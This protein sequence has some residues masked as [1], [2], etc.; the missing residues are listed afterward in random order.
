VYPFIHL[1]PITLGT[2]GLL[3]ATALLVSYFV[4]RADFLRRTLAIDAE[5]VVGITGLAGLVGAR[6]YH[7]MESPREFFAD[8]WPLLFSTMGFAWFGSVIAGF[9]ALVLLARHYKIGFLSMLDAASPAAALGYGVGR[10]GCLISGD[11]DYGKP[12]TLPWGMSFPNGIVPTT[13]RVHPTPIYEFLIAIVIFW[14]LWRIGGRAIRDMRPAGIVFAA[15]LVLTGVARFL[16]EFIRIN[17]RSFFGMTNAQ[18]A[19]LASILAGALLFWFARPAGNGQADAA[20][21]SSG[22]KS[23]RSRAQTASRR[24]RA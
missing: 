11:G 7:L 21:G 9:I 17:P 23:G 3:V 6:L 14:I 19:S 12:T 18:A 5:T 2:Y 8:P 15:Y 16:I 24:A 1:G 20:P 22:A 4:L 13:E 10:I